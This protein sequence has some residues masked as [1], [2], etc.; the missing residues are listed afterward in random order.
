MQHILLRRH[1]EPITI[2]IGGVTIPAANIGFAGISYTGQYQFN[3]TI[4]QG[5]PSGDQAIV[6]TVGGI[7]SPAGFV[8]TI[9]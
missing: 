5:I 3:V 8:V 7:Q 6:A 1:R 9:H 4:P 2:T